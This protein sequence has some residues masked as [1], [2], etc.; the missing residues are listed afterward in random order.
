[1]GLQHSLNYLLHE[2]EN[3]AP[4]QL[5]IQLFNWWERQAL[6]KGFIQCKVFLEIKVIHES[7]LFGIRT[8]SYYCEDVVGVKSRRGIL[9][10]IVY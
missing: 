9:Q 4:E 2:G 6:K 8:G 3:R 10:W 7:Q 5:E 1:M